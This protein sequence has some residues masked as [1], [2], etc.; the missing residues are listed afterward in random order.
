MCFLVPMIC[1]SIILLT[2][3]IGY[4]WILVLIKG[5]KTYEEVKKYYYFYKVDPRNVNEH[6][7]NLIPRN[8]SK[9]FTK[10]RIYSTNKSYYNKLFKPLEKISQNELKNI[11]IIYKTLYENENEEMNQ[12]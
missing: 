10:F 12:I 1:L 6:Y 2:I 4:H 5:S 3:L 8:L 7:M 11:K 9:I